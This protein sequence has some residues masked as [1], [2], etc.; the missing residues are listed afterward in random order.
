MELND[1]QLVLSDVCACRTSPALHG[2]TEQE[3][4]ELQAVLSWAACG[5]QAAGWECLD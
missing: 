5:P 1:V 2:G 4:D 3:S